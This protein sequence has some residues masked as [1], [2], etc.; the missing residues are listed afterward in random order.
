MNDE[1]LRACLLFIVPRSGFRVSENLSS[2]ICVSQTL[3]RISRSR[4]VS[5]NVLVKLENNY[6]NVAQA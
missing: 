2:L 4:A 5:S 6:G 1:L 3:S